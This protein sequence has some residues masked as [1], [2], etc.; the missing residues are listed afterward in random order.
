MTSVIKFTPL[1]G[2]AGQITPPCYLLEIDNFCILLD[3]GWNAKLDISLLDELKKVANKVDAILL[4]YPDTEHI[5]ALPYA[6]GKLGLTGKIYGTTPI[7]KMG[8]IFMY[9]LYTSRMAQEEF[10]RFDLDEV[11]MCFDQSR[12][13]E[14]SYSQHYEIP[15]S[16][17]IIIT[18]YLAGHM[19]G[20]SVWR[21]AKESDVIVYAVD[22]NH[23]RESHLEGFLQNG[24]LSPELAKPTHLITDALHILDPP[25]QKKADKDTAMLAQ[26]RKSLRDGGNILV[27]TDTAGRV[28]ELLLTIDQYW[29]QHRLGSAYSVVF[30]NSVTYYV[31]EFAKSQL[32]FMSTAASSKFEQKNEN[33]FNFRNIKICNSFKQ[34]EELPN[35]TRNYVVLASSKD[36][37]TGFAKDLFIQWAND[38][39]NMVMLTDNMDEGTLGD[40]LSKCQSGIDSIQV[41]HGKRVELEGEELREYEETIQRKKDEEKR[42]EEEKRLQEEKAN[43][44]ERMDVDDQEE[45]ITK[46]NPLLN[47]FDMHRSDFI[48]EHY[49]P[50]FPFTEPIVKWDEYGEQ[51]EELLNIAKELKDQKD[52][53]MKDDVVMEEENKQEEEETKPKKIVTFN[54]M[55]K[56]NCSVTRFDYQGCSDG[57][58]LKTIIQKIAPTNLILVRGNQQ[59]VDELLD[60]AKKSLRV[61]GLFSPAISNQIDLTSETHDSLIK[62]LN[63]SKLMDYEIAYI[64]AKVHIEDII[65]NG[66]TNA[67][68]PLAITSPTTSTAITTTNDSKALTVVQPK[69]KKIIPLLD[70]MP[71][72]E[73]KGHNVSFVG[74]VKL[75]EFK[76][77]LTREGFQVQFDKGILS[78]NGLVYLWREEVDGNSCIN[79]DGVMSEEY[80]LVKELLYSQFKIL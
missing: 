24:L 79:I 67:A 16:D 13:K 31:R 6:I 68:T 78:C 9:D 53:E 56:V 1:C 4:T 22:I 35:L 34:L 14:L 8:Q 51:D 37:E 15:D 55:V 36:L 72:E 54:T 57:Q 29:S 52:K 3:C 21:I 80:Y 71:V 48:N 63:T 45:L 59:C 28:L 73:S 7:H 5:G 18:P 30:F 26:L 10:D 44:K 69:E 40:Q 70:I 27:A 25:P 46:K 39:K 32:E 11:D 75:S 17:G 2:G 12:F 19:V 50:M 41:T 60:F 76:D 38:P 42:L 62:S 47:R 74:D 77:V 49:I 23:R 20:G 65:L 61:K 43:R 58:S 66:A 64:E 33:I